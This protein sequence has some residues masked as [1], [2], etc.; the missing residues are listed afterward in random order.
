MAVMNK[1][2]VY[3]GQLQGPFRANQELM[4]LIEE[5]C[6]TAPKYVKHLGIQ[7]KVTEITTSPSNL[8]QLTICGK[9]TTIEVGT[10]HVYEI[11]NTRVT[12]IKFLENKDN[13]TIIDYIAIL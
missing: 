2:N 8:I 7:T 9:E 13:N 5:Q 12:S 4:K 1:V 11:G 10:T 6:V 3:Q